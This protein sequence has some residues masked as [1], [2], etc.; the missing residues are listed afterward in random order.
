[1]G[2]GHAGGPASPALSY[3][4]AATHDGVVGHWTGA[5]RFPA[6]PMGGSQAGDLG[7]LRGESR[8][9]VR[10]AELA[11]LL[12]VKGL[13]SGGA[14]LMFRG[15]PGPLVKIDRPAPSTFQ[16]QLA[17]LRDYSDLRSERIGEINL[18][19]GDLL[20]FFGAAAF[21][22]ASRRKYTLELLHTILRQT[23]RLGYHF[24]HHC[25]AA[26]PI[27]LSDQVHPVI[28]TPD[29]SAFPSGHATESFAIATVLQ[30]LR[31]P[32]NPPGTGPLSFEPPT[33]NGN[34]IADFPGYGM[35]FRIAAR[36]A[37]NRTIAGVHF[38]I[39]SMAGA[40]L[41]HSI[42][43]AMA[44]L[45]T[46]RQIAAGPTPAPILG[47]TEDFTL[48]GLAAN[49]TAMALTFSEGPPPGDVS[50]FRELWRLAQTEWPAPA[51]ADGPVGGRD[52]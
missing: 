5:A 1:M 38:P 32:G 4:L 17:W 31:H 34:P 36:I 22:N 20:S 33:R 37:V 51:P 48:P 7:Y 12:A 41:G 29:H 25:R 15:M 6:P 19:T 8:A 44:A 52:Q 26:R 35:L 10:D 42:G 14:E 13:A 18:Q 23:V 24:K 40:M 43:M 45:G 3:A 49:L 39:D 50:C 2:L 11:P 47:D 21:L 16:A 28:Q 27:D 9:H 30:M 46:G